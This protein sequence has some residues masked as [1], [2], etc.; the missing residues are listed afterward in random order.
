MEKYIFYKDGSLQRPRNISKQVFDA[1]QYG[2][3]FN[4]F[5]PSDVAVTKY[6]FSGSYSNVEYSK[7]ISLKNTINYYFGTSDSF[8]YTS[9]V[10]KPVSILSLS[11]YHLG[12]GIQ[13]G[14]I[15]LSVLNTTS[16]ATDKR[17][18]GILYDQD[19]AEVG[20]VLY[21]EGFVILTSDKVI[22]GSSCNIQV[23]GGVSSSNSYRWYHFAASSSLD[24]S[25]GFY[26][27]T[28]SEASTYMTFVYAE[29]GELNHSNNSTYLKSGSYKPAAT[30]TSFI[31]NISTNPKQPQLEI[32]NT[33]YSPINKVDAPLQKNVYITNIGLYDKDR[34]LI[35]V[36][37]LANPIKK[38]EIREFLFKI[39]LD[40]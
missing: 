7:V 2:N 18:N 16:S 19:D 15:E 24:L 35:G 31:E 17:E 28:I 4:I 22:S 29:K 10:D 23:A 27:N 34:K 21:K 9:I 37:N 14:S 25:C 38:T 1:A 32:K 5:E 12:S 8:K 36:A 11:S 39:K 13:K 30:S 3:I 40:I 26:Y 20:F 6:C 33:V